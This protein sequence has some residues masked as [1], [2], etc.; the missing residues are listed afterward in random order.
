M[1]FTSRGNLDL[2][3]VSNNETQSLQ[4]FEKIENVMCNSTNDNHYFQALYNNNNHNNN[5]NNNNNKNVNNNINKNVK[6]DISRNMNYPRKN[7]IY[8]KQVYTFQSNQ[9]KF[10]NPKSSLPLKRFT[11]HFLTILNPRKPKVR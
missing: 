5:N 3:L 8:L 4:I 11:V 9:I 7:L 1:L 10:E 2:A 6:Y